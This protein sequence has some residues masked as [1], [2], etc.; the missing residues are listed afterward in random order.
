MEPRPQGFPVLGTVSPRYS[1]M[2][3]WPA[4]PRFCTSAPERH[5]GSSA[6]CL[7][8]GETLLW[9]KWFV[10]KLKS[11]FKGFEVNVSAGGAPGR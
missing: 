11:V 6:V 9:E 10:Q 8:P 3:S 2:L 5:P 7:A 4:S 1:P